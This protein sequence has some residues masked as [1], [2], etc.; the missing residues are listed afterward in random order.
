MTHMGPVKDSDGELGEAKPSD[1]KCH[2][3]QL[4]TLQIWESSDGAYEDC[5][6]TCP[7]GHVQWV[8]GID[9]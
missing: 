5:K 3:G 8:D 6:Y 4:M 7:Q 2:C 1:R 9:S